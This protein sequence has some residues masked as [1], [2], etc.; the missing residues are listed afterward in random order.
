MFNVKKKPTITSVQFELEVK[1]YLESTSGK[2]KDFQ[3]V[4]RE[5]MDGQDGTYEIDITARFRIFGADFLVL[6]E[7]KNHKNHIKREHVQMLH[8]K[9]VSLSA[10]KAMLFATTPFQDGAVEYAN[11]HGIA[12]VQL[13]SGETLYFTKS[14]NRTPLPDSLPAYVGWLIAKHDRA[15]DGVSH[16]LV[17]PQYPDALNKFL[18]GSSAS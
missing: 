11:H 5:S 4:H 15:T 3:T 16:S 9:Q 7:C 8:A 2:L 13:A 1:K 14:G 6:V 10:Q 12:L 17:D 18:F